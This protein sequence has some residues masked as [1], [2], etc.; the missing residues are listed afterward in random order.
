MG[1]GLK[2]A[3]AAAKATR[4]KPKTVEVTIVALVPTDVQIKDVIGVDA[5]GLLRKLQFTLKP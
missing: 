4:A 2:R 5:H 1:E 3:F